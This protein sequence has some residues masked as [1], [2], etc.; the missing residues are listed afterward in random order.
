M[1]V[2]DVCH[3]QLDFQFSSDSISITVEF[4][5]SVVQPVCFYSKATINS[6]V[7]HSVLVLGKTFR[8]LDSQWIVLQDGIDWV[9]TQCGFVRIQDVNDLRVVGFV[10]AVDIC[11]N[12]TA[13]EGQLYFH[14]DV[15][16]WY[17]NFW[18]AHS[19]CCWIEVL[20]AA[21]SDDPNLMD[22]EFE[23]EEQ[24]VQ[25]THLLR[26]GYT[27]VSLYGLY[28]RRCFDC[29]HSAQGFVTECPSR[30]AHATIAKG[31]RMSEDDRRSLQKKLQT[32]LQFWRITAPCDRP[33]DPRICHA[34]TFWVW[35]EVFRGVIGCRRC[36]IHMWEREVVKEYLKSAC[37]E[38]TYAEFVP[39]EAGF[40]AHVLR[41]YDR[42]RERFEAAEQRAQRLPTHDGWLDLQAEQSVHSNLDPW[43]SRELIDLCHYLADGA[44]HFSGMY[45]KI[46]MG[47]A[48]VKL[49]PPYV[50]WKYHVTR[51][52]DWVSAFDG[53]P[54]SPKAR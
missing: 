15:S 12:H 30:A 39:K 42:D 10:R 50:H 34:K 22:M 54:P 24:Q 41:L 32:V 5:R 11:I 14:L 49:I 17:G 9:Q 53:D 31:A 3:H 46:R 2:G 45:F 20:D 18:I 51:P 35:L 7:V 38:D 44:H 1:V 23:D 33:H 16:K 21:P 8:L 6:D 40:D 37:I 25:A 29:E 27:Y 36:R 26:E 4:K 28:A 43:L 48:K 52:T 47:D 13:R 19:D